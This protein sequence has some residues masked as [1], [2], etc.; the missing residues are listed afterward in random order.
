[1]YVCTQCV[2]HTFWWTRSMSMFLSHSAALS[3]PILHMIILFMWKRKRKILSSFEITTRFHSFCFSPFFLGQFS[4]CVCVVVVF[5]VATRSGNN[6]EPEQK[7]EQKSSNYI[8]LLLIWHTTD[9]D[10]PTH[11]F[12]KCSRMTTRCPYFWAEKEEEGKKWKENRLRRDR[13]RDRDT[14]LKELKHG[15][16]YAPYASDNRFDSFVCLYMYMSE[17]KWAFLTCVSVVL[18]MS[19]GEKEKP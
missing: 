17:K 3:T 2:L 11:A 6:N 12:I 16:L 9:N 10:R 19:S 7:D 8:I 4:L 18:D 15:C 13:A 5:D 14:S 1:M